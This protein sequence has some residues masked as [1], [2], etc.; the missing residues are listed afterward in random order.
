MRAAVFEGSFAGVENYP[1]GASSGPG[2]NSRPDG[3]HLKPLISLDF[4]FCFQVIAEV[5]ARQVIIVCRAFRF[6]KS[7][8]PSATNRRFVPGTM[9]FTAAFVHQKNAAARTL[10]CSVCGS[11]GLVCFRRQEIRRSGFAV[12]DQ[13]IP[14]AGQ[15][16]NAVLATGIAAGEGKT[17][18]HLRILFF[19]FF[20]H[21]GQSNH[22]Y[23]AFEIMLSA[24][25]VCI[26][27][28]FSYSLLRRPAC[29]GAAWQYPQHPYSHLR[30]TWAAQQF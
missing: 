10:P 17:I 27:P 4:L 14:F 18:P 21:F 6:M 1:A 20:L 23:T 29:P 2:K 9:Q 25:A 5:E 12:R 15:N 22:F 16:I 28:H 26:A 19:T 30:M 8:G 24:N 11:A 7:A 3:G 13:K